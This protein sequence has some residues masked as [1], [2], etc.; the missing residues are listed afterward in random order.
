MTHHIGKYGDI[1]YL[2]GINSIL[3]ATIDLKF[4][5]TWAPTNKIIGDIPDITV[6]NVPIF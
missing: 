2:S 4:V 1:D 3:Y 6:L 5:G